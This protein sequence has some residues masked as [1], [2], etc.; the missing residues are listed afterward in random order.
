[1]GDRDPLD[2]FAQPT[3]NPV[4][5]ESSESPRSAINASES[6]F[7]G[8]MSELGAQRPADEATELDLRDVTIAALREMLE[9][10]RPL[11][12]QLADSEQRRLELEAR[13]EAA[14]CATHIERT[15]ELEIEL[16]RLKRA[17]VQAQT[18]LKKVR[19]RSAERQ[20]VA[21]QR[22]REIQ[23]LRSE[24]TRLANELRRLGRASEGDDT[25]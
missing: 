5:K 9:G 23:K 1:M 6:E 16:T 7:A 4:S 24:R 22:W 12:E 18:N 15:N 14:V 20:R 2:D 21:T 19:A 8:W 3:A 10:L 25:D 11:G 13:L 17:L